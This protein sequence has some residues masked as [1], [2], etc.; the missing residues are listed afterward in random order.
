MLLLVR[1]DAGCTLDLV[2]AETIAV[3]ASSAIG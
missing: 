3:A 2:A 1:S